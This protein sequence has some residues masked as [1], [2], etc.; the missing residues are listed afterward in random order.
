[1]NRIGNNICVGAPNSKA[2]YNTAKH[3]SG[4]AVCRDCIKL[5][6]KDKSTMI[7]NIGMEECYVCEHGKDNCY[8]FIG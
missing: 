6:E 5:H 4:A 7:I 2:R 1:M 3:T 8:L